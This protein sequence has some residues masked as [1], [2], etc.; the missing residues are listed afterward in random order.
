MNFSFLDKVDLDTDFVTAADVVFERLISGLG[1]GDV[2]ILMPMDSG[3]NRKM[4]FGMH[5]HN[6]PELSIVLSGALLFQ[7]PTEEIVLNAGSVCVIPARIPHVEEVIGTEDFLGFVITEQAGL[8]TMHFAKPRGNR[9]QPQ[10][11]GSHNFT[12]KR[13]LSGYMVQAMRW[14]DDP[15]FSKGAVYILQTYFHA[16]RELINKQNEERKVRNPKVARCIELARDHIS[17][18][19]LSVALLAEWLGCN[20]DYLSNLFHKETG[21]R[22]KEW[23]VAQRVLLICELLE[24]T[25]MS[26][27]EIAQSSGFKCTAYMRKVFKERTAYSP[28]QYRRYYFGTN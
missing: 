14:L 21:Q 7:S 10:N 23:I 3:A 6:E 16:C 2:E 15:N 19:K 17:D 18:S 5:F 20:A 12:L 11:I 8:I 24:D 9:L 28:S 1:I 13:S 25:S 4:Q 22:L 27:T 26:I